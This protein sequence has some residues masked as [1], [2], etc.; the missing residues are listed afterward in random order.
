MGTYPPNFCFPKL[1][2][3]HK[4][5]PTALLSQFPPRFVLP[6][7]LSSSLFSFVETA[8][9]N[10]TVG[11]KTR[12]TKTHKTLFYSN[13]TNHRLCTACAH[14]GPEGKE[15]FIVVFDPRMYKK[16]DLRV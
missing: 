3:P 9:V 7:Y 4:K 16:R 8:R 15:A 1:I 14:V 12:R 2:G 13:N 11:K 6:V 5:R 10:C